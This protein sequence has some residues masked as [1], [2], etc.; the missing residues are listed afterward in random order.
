MNPNT[1]IEFENTV[2][3]IKNNYSWEGYISRSQGLNLTKFIVSH[4]EIKNI[5]EI[6]FNLGMSSAYMLNIS[7]KIN[8]CSFDLV[9]CK[10]KVIQKNA[11]DF[12]FPER[13]TLIVGDSRN[14]IPSFSKLFKEPF[15]DFIFLDGG[16]TNDIP[17]NDMFNSLELLK[18]GGFMCIDDYIEKD[19]CNGVIKGYKKILEKNLVKELYIESNDEYTC[20]YCQKL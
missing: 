14:T 1:I 3:E 5:C 4:P 17:E 9:N 15:F 2:E 18:P 10:S 6:G 11:I 19:W 20:V 16:H 12:Y 13:H 8:V 7:E